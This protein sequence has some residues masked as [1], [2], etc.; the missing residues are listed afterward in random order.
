MPSKQAPTLR[1]P[2]C[3]HWS[4]VRE[5]LKGINL[6]GKVAVVTWGYAGIGRETT[7]AL[8]KSGAMVIAPARSPDNPSFMG[9]GKSCRL[10][11]SDRHSLTLHV[12]CA[13]S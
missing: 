2:T 10:F 3:K 7:R 12:G 6:T 11:G 13:A 5:R 9:L 8:A 1:F 4:T